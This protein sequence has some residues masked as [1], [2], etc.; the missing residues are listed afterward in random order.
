MEGVIF[1]EYLPYSP[2]REIEETEIPEY[3]CWISCS[4]HSQAKHCLC[5]EHGDVSL[6]QNGGLTI[7][8]IQYCLN[9]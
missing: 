6:Q 3:F 2:R 7:Y 1:M 5:Y 9:N 4:Q 8:L